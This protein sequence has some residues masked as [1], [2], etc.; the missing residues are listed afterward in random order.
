MKHN[1]LP[2]IDSV[3]EVF[4]YDPSTGILNPLT[5]RKN[6]RLDT[7][8]SGYSAVRLSDSR[9]PYA[10]I[11]YYLA[12][13][14]DPG[15]KEIDHI[16]RNPFNNKLENL[17]LATRSQQLANR[18]KTSAAKLPKGVTYNKQRKHYS[19]CWG[20]DGKKI[21]VHGFMTAD[22]AHL[23]YLWNT[24][25][26]GE[27]SDY[28]PPSACPPHPSSWRKNLRKKGTKD[29]PK[30]VSEVRVRQPDGTWLL[31]GYQACFKSSKGPM[32]KKGFKTPEEAHA[33]YLENRLVKTND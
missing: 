16:D 26:H 32:T 18:R 33:F 28:L 15:D 29:L 23:F 24:R 8:K 3:K 13:G 31:R 1:P 17:R 12:T 11:C 10:R 22:E 9:Y 7:E 21:S 25:H 30:A 19:A 2:C 14:I 27:F 20:Q 6:W 4:N 5:P